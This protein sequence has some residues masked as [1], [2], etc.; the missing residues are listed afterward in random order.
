MR[1]IGEPIQQDHVYEQH[2][3]EWL[4]KVMEKVAKI[5]P[6]EIT[7]KVGMPLSMIKNADIKE[8]TRIYGDLK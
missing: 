1:T 3:Q 8:L 7:M 6:E 2:R 5:P 4:K